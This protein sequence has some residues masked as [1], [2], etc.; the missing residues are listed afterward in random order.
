MIPFHCGQALVT[1]TSISLIFGNRRK[2]DSFEKFHM[3]AKMEM[4]L[5]YVR[6]TETTITKILTN[7]HSISGQQV[8]AAIR[9]NSFVS[10]RYAVASEYAGILCRCLMTQKA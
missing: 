7:G 8:N 5:L 10:I 1:L 9:Q 4:N 2:S 6:I 3:Q